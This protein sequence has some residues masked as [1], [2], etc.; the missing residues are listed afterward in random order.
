MLRDAKIEN[1][2]FRTAYCCTPDR[3]I[4]AE[5][6][7]ADSETLKGML[8]KLHMPFT[9]IMEATKIEG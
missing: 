9:V 7:S 2:K 8:K 3:K 1:V 6:E 4:I 5:F